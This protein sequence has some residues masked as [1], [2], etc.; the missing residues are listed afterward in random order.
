[1]GIASAFNDDEGGGGGGL[2]GV[3]SFLSDPL[4]IF[5][6]RAGQSGRNAARETSE[7][8]LGELR[9]QFDIGQSRIEPFF[10][11]A[12]PAFQL[13]A[14]FSGSRGP[15]AQR[16]AFAGFQESPNVAFLR[17]QGL[18]GVEGQAAATGGLGGGER[19]R[20]LT[21]FS[22]GLALQDFENQFNRLGIISGRG[23]TAGSELAQRGSQFGAQFGNVL[24]NESQA[25]QQSLQNQQQQTSAVAGAGLGALSSFLSDENMKTED[26]KSVV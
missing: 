26:R 16:E 8:Q 25:I 19:L 1:M 18:R 4:D 20:E 15:E 9:R 14:A 24:G 5:G 11:E 10:Q 17:E 7:Q 6:Q 21:R 13:Q 22:Q 3:V 23:Q 2:G 12:V